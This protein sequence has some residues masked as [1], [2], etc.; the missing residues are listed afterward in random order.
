[1]KT[2]ISIQDITKKFFSSKGETD[3]INNIS[4]DLYENEIVA[5]L[6]PSGCGKSTLLNILSKLENVTSGKVN[7][8]CKLG[9]MFQKDN[10]M[11]W[12][13]IYNNITLGLEINH[14][15]TKE[16]LEYVDSL[17]KNMIYMILKIIT[18]KNYLE[19]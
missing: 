2:L 18:L 14:L 1:M 19:V 6:G 12:R 17:L 10:L 7:I 11:D 16:N 13:N 15:K 8:N 9:Y 3:V 5:L 4:F